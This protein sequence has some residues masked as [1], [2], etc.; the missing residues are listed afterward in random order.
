MK[1][2][3]CQKDVDVE[4]WRY[5]PNCGNGL[6]DEKFSYYMRKIFLSKRN[7]A[8]FVILEL[9]FFGALASWIVYS[10][11]KIS[12]KNKQ[13]E[14]LEKKQEVQAEAKIPEKISPILYSG[15][16]KKMA[17]LM[18]NSPVYGKLRVEMEVPG[19]INKYS[20]TINIRP[21]SKIYNLAPDI[22]E[23]G[24]KNLS[25]S[26]KTNLSLKVFSVGDDNQEKKIL[27]ERKE[28]FFYSRN[29]IVWQDEN[30]ANNADYIVRLVNKDREEIKEL[31]RKAA[32]HMKELGGSNNAMVGMQG[33]EAEIKR[34]MEAIF[35]AMAEDY[36]IRYVMAP[37]SYDS[38]SAQKIKSPEEVIQT[39]SGLCIEL[40]LL[41]AAALENIGL[42]PVLVLTNDHA[43]AG[44]ELGAKTDKYIFIETTALEES[45]QDAASVAQ[46]NWAKIKN[47]G[48]ARLVKI[49]EMRASGINPIKY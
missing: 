15:E 36:K 34:Q 39:K 18:V 26:K 25:D 47:S 19:V 40:S 7:L 22:S 14:M 11:K 21:E 41:M 3:Q 12:D 8:I 44:V 48:S 4:K 32:D 35:M 29:D 37:F 46:K 45:P 20:E 1:C 16:G 9:V 28:I 23:E 5:C 30:G 6:T 33:N 17:E 31:V 13:I 27:E 10:N 42:N 2:N 24:Y 38:N 43:W 49:N